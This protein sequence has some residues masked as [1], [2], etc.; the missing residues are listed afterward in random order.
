MKKNYSSICDRERIF[1]DISLERDRQDKIYGGI[2]K[3]MLPTMLSV[4]VEEVGECAKELNEKLPGDT[5]NLEVE[6]VQVAAV[7]VKWLEILML[8]DSPSRKKSCKK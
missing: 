8:K 7:C 6:L 5:D 3:C 4:L 2:D 1:D